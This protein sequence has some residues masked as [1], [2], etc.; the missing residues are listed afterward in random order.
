MVGKYPAVVPTIRGSAHITG[1]RQFLVDSR[2]P[3]PFGFSLEKQEKL[4]G[5]GFNA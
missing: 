2:D 1:I 3:F 5:F 4:Y